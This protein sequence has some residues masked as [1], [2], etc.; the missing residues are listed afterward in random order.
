MFRMG[1]LDAASLAYQG[2]LLRTGPAATYER[3]SISDSI[4]HWCIA[5]VCGPDPAGLP[6]A[7]QALE[8][9]GGTREGVRPVASSPDFGKVRTKGELE[10]GLVVISRSTE[11]ND[12]TGYNGDPVGAIRYI[13]SL[14]RYGIPEI[15]NAL[16]AILGVWMSFPQK[17][18]RIEGSP[19]TRR[20]IAAACIVF[21]IAG[22]VISVM[23]RRDSDDKM[24]QLV[25]ASFSQAT[26][27]DITSLG[28]KIDSG[29]ER[30]VAAIGL[31]ARGVKLPPIKP[32]NLPVKVEP[33]PEHIR[34]VEKR[35]PSTDPNSEYG[36]QVIIQTD[37][38]IQ[39][40]SLG[41]LCD[42]QIE[43]ANN[44]VVGV[45][46][47]MSYF[48]GIS[49]DHLEYV[50]GYQSPPF[51][52]LTPIVVTLFSKLPFHVKHI[53]ENPEIITGPHQ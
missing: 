30:T 13:L 47:R 48:E 35:V 33:P 10:R 8:S 5:L 16:L 18:E 7:S 34:Y 51:T 37:A 28:A 31:I 29:F 20:I 39:P 50:L 49:D 15:A 24:R 53:Q 46:A 26:K 21:G 3:W 45:N 36:L 43:K 19:I 52:P 4:T 25:S 9:A 1:P 27:D 17:A 40:I 44:F 14:F 38:Q 11:P 22:L 23:Q 32:P 6:P 42:A 12:C 41:I 2:N